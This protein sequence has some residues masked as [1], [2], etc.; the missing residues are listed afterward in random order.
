M[1]N[2]VLS[3]R[4]RSR[5]SPIGGCGRRF[6]NGL[7]AALP[8]RPNVDQ[9]KLGGLVRPCIE[10]SRGTA[11]SSAR[12]YGFSRLVKYAPT[13]PSSTLPP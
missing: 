11:D 4:T 7:F 10:P 13:E 12:V 3:P 1:S 9:R 8:L 6:G 2:R 5:V